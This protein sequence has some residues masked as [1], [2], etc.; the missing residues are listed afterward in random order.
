MAVLPEPLITKFLFVPEIAP[1]TL[2]SPEPELL[3][4]VALARVIAESASPI[5]DTAPM[6][7]IPDKVMEDAAVA[8]NPP[9]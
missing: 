7:T 5:D 2:M 8:V 3:K 4:V 1:A 9:E 6:V